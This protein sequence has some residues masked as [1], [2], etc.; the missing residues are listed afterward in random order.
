M[1]PK[2]NLD[3]LGYELTEASTPGGNYVSVNVR[4]NIAYVET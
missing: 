1:T 4:E 3:K 2:E